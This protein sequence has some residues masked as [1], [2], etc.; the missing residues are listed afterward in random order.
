MRSSFLFFLAALLFLPR[1][2]AQSPPDADTQIRA[3]VKAAPSSL[4][5]TAAVRGYTNDGTVTT[6]REGTGP[7]VCLADDPA[8]D[9]FKSACYHKSLAPFM[10]RGR[11]LRRQG[12]T[13]VDSVRRA[14]IEAGTLA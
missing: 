8:S 1:A 12:V 5:S 11:N 6:L 7:L 9:G 4:R 2:Y 13:A 14:E 10:Q 3:A